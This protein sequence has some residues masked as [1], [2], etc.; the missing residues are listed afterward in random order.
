MREM[1]VKTREQSALRDRPAQRGRGV[2]GIAMPL[3]QA[4]PMQPAR[5]MQ[6]VCHTRVRAASNDAANQAT[7]NRT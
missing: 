3:R 7:K 1:W 6:A 4:T 5:Q 2:A